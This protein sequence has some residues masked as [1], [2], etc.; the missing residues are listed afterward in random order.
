VG[1]EVLQNLGDKGVV[2]GELLVE[3]FKEEEGEMVGNQFGRAVV[4]VSPE[5]IEAVLSD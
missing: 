4:Q 1:G 2:V 5:L 3:D